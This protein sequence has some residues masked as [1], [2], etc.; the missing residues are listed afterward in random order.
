MAHTT[1]STMGEMMPATGGENA[2][3]RTAAARATKPA[4]STVEELFAALMVALERRKTSVDT[5][6]LN[7]GGKRFQT[8]AATLTSVKRSFFDG[9]CSGL[10]RIE[11]CADGSYFIDRPSQVFEHVLN[12]MRGVELH[13]ELLSNTELVL[14]RTEAQF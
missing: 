2:D 1:A 6:A 5:A 3:G 7:V 11:P 4:K 9:L 12:F 14:L 8:S 13:Y 10:S